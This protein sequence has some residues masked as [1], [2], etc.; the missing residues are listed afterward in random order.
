MHA[1]PSPARAAAP[2]VR[3]VRALG[4]RAAA[5]P[6]VTF[7]LAGLLILGSALV[8]ARHLAV[9]TDSSHMLSDRLPHRQRELALNAAFPGLNSR[10]VVLVDAPDADRADAALARLAAAIAARPQALDDPF[11]A[12]LA[13]FFQRNG[14]LYMEDAALDSMLAKLSRAGPLLGTL[15]AEPTLSAFMA[16]LAE[17]VADADRIA[18]GPEAL[19]RVIAATDAT[20]RARLE[21]K[22]R[23]LAFSTLFADD[24]GPVRRVLTVQ[25]KLDFT[26]FQPARPAREAL[27]A[28]IAEAT[29]APG[30]GDVRIS[31]TGDP[32]MRSEELKSVTEGLGLALVVSLVSVGLLMAVAFRRLALA[33]VALAV[34]L[35][36]LGLAAAFAALAFPALNL[37]SMAFAVLLTG[38][39]ADYAIHLIL[40]MEEPDGDWPTTAADLGLAL[41]L[42]ALTTALGFLAFVPTPFVGMAQLGLIGAF[43]VFA[44]FLAAVVLVPAGLALARRRPRPDRQSPELP[45]AVTRLAFPV[46]LALLV[47]AAV[48]APRARFETDPMALR[49]PDA[50]SVRAFATLFDDKATRPYSASLLVGSEAEAEA[51]AERLLA[52]PEVDHVV[53]PRRLLPGEDAAFRYDAIDAVAAG[54]LPQ[55]QADAPAI[56]T[57]KGMAKLETAL[58][59]AT[60]P[61][62]VR[63]RESLAALRAAAA[64]DPGL[65]AAVERDIFTFWPQTLARLE[66]SLAP[67]PAPRL[68]DL[69]APL[70]S[71]Y[72]NVA[73]QV[74]VE[75]VPVADLRDPAARA[76]FVAAIRTVAPD[77]AGPVVNLEESGAVIA[78]AMLTATLLA[79]AACGLVLLAVTR[80]PARTVATLVP[81]VAAIHLTVGLSALLKLPFNY[82][83]VIALP[84]LL[85]AGID[86]AIHLSARAR[87]AGG[88]EAALASSTPRAVV[89][90]ALTTIAAFG[91]LMLSAHRGVA[92]IGALLLVA[93][94]STT[95]STLVLQPRALALAERLAARRGPV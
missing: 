27:A 16:S 8:A 64:R 42:C 26:L 37:V 4:A 18:G 70:L 93:L 3:L 23:P 66:T 14:L 45:H 57:A 50:P 91:S 49:D 54:L 29:A 9:D 83:N 51:A 78:R 48:A 92:S 39:G 41:F 87:A 86:S 95:V 62:Q 25:P 90:A 63:L 15:A 80:D 20:V 58:A 13:P 31:V 2:V 74:R 88:T 85:G 33:L 53:T 17:G 61:E 38:L 77:V 47:V 28:A 5:R 32:A 34:V 68:Q 10:F 72:L 73:G 6:W 71:R 11:A 65:L 56:D 84:M 82:A 36:A 19:A 35:V 22:P 89:F 12:P 79:L 75:I 59:G 21:G 60:L 52:L 69:P 1:P 67:D 55:L 7:L 81:V 43:G 40:R 24:A 30:L 46:L 76:R 94:A 44:A